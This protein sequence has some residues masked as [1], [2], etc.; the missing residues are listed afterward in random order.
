MLKLLHIS[1]D[2]LFRFYRG[3][4]QISK[5]DTHAYYHYVLDLNMLRP[6]EV[7]WESYNSHTVTTRTVVHFN[8]LHL[9]QWV[10][11]HNCT[12]GA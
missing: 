11:L 10:V 8:H 7:V 4:G 2:W 12:C 3:G 9:G 5:L 1:I 6:D